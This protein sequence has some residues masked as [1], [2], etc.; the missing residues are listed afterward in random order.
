MKSQ[1]FSNNY[2]NESNHG[3]AENAYGDTDTDYFTPMPNKFGLKSTKRA[4]F[5]HNLLLPTKN[6]AEMKK[7]MVGGQQKFSEMMK[8]RYKLDQMYDKVRTVG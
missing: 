1:S 8:N 2:T 6:P 3:I 4:K 5:M 7:L